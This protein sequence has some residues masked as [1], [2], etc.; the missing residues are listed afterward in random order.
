M[1]VG[2]REKGGEKRRAREASRWSKSSRGAVT[3]PVNS[4]E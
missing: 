1:R 2:V 3:F 4:R